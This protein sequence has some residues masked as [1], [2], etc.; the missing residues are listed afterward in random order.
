MKRQG[1]LEVAAAG[2]VVVVGMLSAAVFRRGPRKDHDAEIAELRERI[3]GLE[4]DL[5]IERIARRQLER[6]SY[7]DRSG[8][9]PAI[10]G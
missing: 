9:N 2:V 7:P 6:R 5:E 10:K 1:L 4:A 8:S 3:N